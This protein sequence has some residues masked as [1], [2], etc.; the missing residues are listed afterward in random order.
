MLINDSWAF[1]FELV[2]AVGSIITAAAIFYLWKQSRDTQTQIKLTRQQT[3]YMREELDI[4]LR[5][6]IGVENVEVRSDLTFI[7]KNYGRIP[8]KIV[9]K[10]S[11]IDKTKISK[12][13]LLTTEVQNVEKMMLF[14]GVAVP[15]TLVMRKEP[16]YQYV[17]VM[18]EYEYANNKRGRYGLIGRHDANTRDFFYE[19]TFAN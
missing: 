12:D 11:V 6:W 4:T 9:T 8:G 2:A 7:V 13:R 18:M 15:M 17:A 5:A 14:P 10:R 3:E 1:A 19:E 16:E